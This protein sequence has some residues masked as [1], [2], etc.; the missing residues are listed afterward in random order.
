MNK[1]IKK[2]II[3]FFL[4]AIVLFPTISAGN[5]DNP[6]FEDD[7]GDVV[8]LEEQ[9]N[10]LFNLFFKNIDIVSGWFYEKSEDPDTLYVALKMNNLRL[11][12]FMVV[13]GVVWEF[14]GNYYGC[15]LRTHSKGDYFDEIVVYYDEQGEHM[16][17]IPGIVSFDTQSN[18]IT[19]SVPKDIVGDLQPGDKISSFYANA[20]LRKRD[21]SPV[22]GVWNIL[23]DRVQASQF[24]S[25][26]IQY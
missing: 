23:A 15:G 16:D 14:N 25:Y 1:K 3:C 11:P 22:Q 18:I 24:K 5:E 7:I 6:E 4:G 17:T 19:I 10:P 2:I 21:E 13:Y 20:L 12:Y 8:Y 26:T 9:I